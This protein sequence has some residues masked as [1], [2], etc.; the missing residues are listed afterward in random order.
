[1]LCCVLVF[2]Q[3]LSMQGSVD[4]NRYSAPSLP[5]FRPRIN[6]LWNGVQL[7][8][9]PISAL[10]QPNIMTIGRCCISNYTCTRLFQIWFFKAISQTTL[11]CYPWITILFIKIN[12]RFAVDIF[13]NPFE[14]QPCISA[15]FHIM[16]STQ[17][18][19]RVYPR[20]YPGYY[21]CQESQSA[22]SQK[23]SEN[24]CVWIK[25]C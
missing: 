12:W 1:M 21:L 22:H 17:N 8:R 10:H 18:Y 20:A 3:F 14:S 9:I 23:C 6:I 11:W 19:P 4:L 24:V 25:I 16:L 5:L 15:S 2:L 7:L 13:E